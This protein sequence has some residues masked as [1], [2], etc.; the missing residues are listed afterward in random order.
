MRG[1]IILQGVCPF[2]K[3]RETGGLSFTKKLCVQLVP[4]R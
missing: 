2:D 4:E 1:T 3:Q